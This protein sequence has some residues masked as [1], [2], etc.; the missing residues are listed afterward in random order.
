[1]RKKQVMSI[2]EI[3]QQVM[4]EE[5]LES[6]LQQQRLLAAWPEVI[7]PAM[8]AYT[9]ELFLKNQTLIVRVTSSVLRQ[10]LYLAK[11]VLIRNLNRKAGAQVITDIVFR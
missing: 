4:R 1:M 10:E 7:G 6:P 11:A 5:G 9:S 2:G 8:T 3:L